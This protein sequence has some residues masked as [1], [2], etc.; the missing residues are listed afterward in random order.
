MLSLEESS[1]TMDII[2]VVDDLYNRLLDRSFEEKQGGL[3][4]VLAAVSY[5]HLD[6]YKRQVRRRVRLHIDLAHGDYGRRR[7]LHGEIQ[8][9]FYKYEGE[10]GGKPADEASKASA[11]GRD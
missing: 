3:D 9:V 4:E 8:G 11:K 10:G 6:V 7:R 2:R 1:E 5:T